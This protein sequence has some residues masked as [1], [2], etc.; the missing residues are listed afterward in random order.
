MGN[1]KKEKFNN[2]WTSIPPEEIIAGR[3]YS[4]SFNPSDQPT[5]GDKSGPIKDDFLKNY[6]TEL[7]NLFKRLKYC[8]IE[9]YAELSQ[10]GRL[11]Y[12]G[13]ISITD[14]ARFY[15]FE[16]HK[17]MFHGSFEIDHL[18]DERKWFLYVTKQTYLMKPFCDD[19]GIHYM[20][21]TSNHK[22]EVRAKHKL[23][24]KLES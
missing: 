14:I 16:I 8:E 23:P 17:L 5:R 13:W 9:I 4:F 22:R 19:Y 1:G 6:D 12:H 18:F 20:L 24:K 10:L 11:H 15:M 7:V 3:T 21:Q 2:R